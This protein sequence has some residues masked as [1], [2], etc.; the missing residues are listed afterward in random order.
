MN[1]AQ[2]ESQTGKI[3]RKCNEVLE[4]LAITDQS[5]TEKA[6][7]LLGPI[8]QPDEKAK[9]AMIGGSGQMDQIHMLLERLHVKAETLMHS[10]RRFEG[11]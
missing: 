11:L 7:A 3:I 6:D 10:A 8:P 4:T 2:V 1:D 5:L 9:D